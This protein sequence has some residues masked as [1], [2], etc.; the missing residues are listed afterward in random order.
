MLLS[1]LLV[2]LAIS[3]L[4]LAADNISYASEA[5]RVLDVHY[6]RWNSAQQA[7]YSYWMKMDYTPSHFSLGRMYAM[8]AA[9]V[10]SAVVGAAV[11]VGSLTM[12]GKDKLEA[13][14]KGRKLPL[15]VLLLGLVLTLIAFTLN[16]AIA[17]YAWYPVLQWSNE[18]FRDSLPLPATG[19]LA[20]ES[21]VRFQSPFE[22]T[23][24][25]WNCLLAPYVINPAESR[26]L[27]SLCQEATVAKALMMPMMIF[28]AALLICLVWTWRKART[29][30]TEADTNAKEIE[31][32]SA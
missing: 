24:D 9:G 14:V 25:N 28:S 19:S 11:A 30:A 12:R 18:S 7:V 32:I 20:T 5:S 8:V 31:E 17:I 4:G 3:I 26:K 6:I 13:S 2:A 22:F 21:P 27:E 29:A 15:P 23:P 10:I 16:L 1:L